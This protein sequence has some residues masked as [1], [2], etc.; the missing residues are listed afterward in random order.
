MGCGRCT[1]GRTYVRKGYLDLSGTR[2]AQW[3]VSV[4]SRSNTAPWRPRMS[5]RNIGT[6]PRMPESA[7]VRIARIALAVLVVL[8]VLLLQPVTNSALQ[9]PPHKAHIDKALQQALKQN[10]K[11]LRVIVRTEVGKRDR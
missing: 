2:L 7:L 8:A 6:A 1:V 10:Q 4:V 5:R 11:G 3:R 9:P